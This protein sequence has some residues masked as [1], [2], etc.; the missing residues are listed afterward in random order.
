[1]NNLNELMTS[2]KINCNYDEQLDVILNA[3]KKNDL[4][5]IT[6]K[7]SLKGCSALN[8]SGLAERIIE[9][10][11]DATRLENILEELDEIT[12]KDFITLTQA[13]F[14]TSNSIK[15]SNIELLIDFGYVYPTMN[16]KEVVLMAP[17]LVKE[18]FGKLVPD[19]LE[20]TAPDQL[21]QVAPVE[22]VNETKKKKLMPIRVVKIGRNE[23][24]PCHSG[25]KYKKCCGR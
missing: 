16:G 23:L 10:L 17:N 13:D 20:Q 21:E 25:K 19:Q 5:S 9:V 12:K 3:L 15:G 8:K 22:V 14:L 2:R 1:M 7:H 6:D 4:K 11:T 18:T 24:C